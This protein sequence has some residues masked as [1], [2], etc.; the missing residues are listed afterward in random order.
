MRSAGWREWPRGRLLERSRRSRR[1]G[2]TR[3]PLP[4]RAHGGVVGSGSRVPGVLCGEGQEVGRGDHR[5]H[6]AAEPNQLVPGDQPSRSGLS[7]SRPRRSGGGG[8]GGGDEALRAK[9]LDRAELQ[10]G[11]ERFGMGA[12][13]G[14]EGH[15]HSPPLAD[16]VLRLRFLLVGELGLSGGRD[17]AGGH[18]PSKGTRPSLRNPNAAGRG[19][20]GATP[21]PS[22]RSP[23]GR[24]RSGE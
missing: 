9:E 12:L 15:L 10:A 8:S 14:K 19:K 22:L 1:V 21:D 16:G 17:I 5:S 3:T 24:W 6:H 11:K 2:R 18:T 23:R 13:P 4:R 7:K 20:K